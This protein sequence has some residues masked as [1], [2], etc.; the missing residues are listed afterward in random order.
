MKQGGSKIALK[1]DILEG[2]PSDGRLSA[3]VVR[4]AALSGAQRGSGARKGAQWSPVGLGR[5]THQHTR[6]V[7]ISISSCAPLPSK[8]VRQVGADLLGVFGKG[9]D[10]LGA[11]RGG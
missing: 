10:G 11:G 4:F 2:S 1:A 3:P 8:A 6:A 7:A 5:R 9:S